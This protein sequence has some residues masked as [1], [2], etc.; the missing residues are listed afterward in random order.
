MPLSTAP[1]VVTDYRPVYGSVQV[2]VYQRVQR[3]GVCSVPVY[4]FVGGDGAV[5]FNGDGT[6]TMWIPQSSC[7]YS[8]YINYYQQATVQTVYT[9][10][11]CRQQL[12]A[13]LEH[14]LVEHGL[15]TFRHVHHVRSGVWPEI[16]VSD[17]ILA[18]LGVLGLPG[19]QLPRW[20]VPQP[21]VLGVHDLLLGRWA[22]EV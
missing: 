18:H 5:T 8:P 6:F 7:V 20:L 16:P 15:T 17:H 4:Q 3:T 21:G 12:N 9:G 14:E 10:Q 19:L 11:S 22:V 2:P 1:Y 13:R